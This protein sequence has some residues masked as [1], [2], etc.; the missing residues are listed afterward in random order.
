M[1]LGAGFAMQIFFMNGLLD[2]SYAKLTSTTHVCENIWFSH[3]VLKKQA[4]WI[5]SQ[6][7]H[8]GLICKIQFSFSWCYQYVF[9]TTCFVWSFMWFD[10]ILKFLKMTDYVDFVPYS[11]GHKYFYTSS[12]FT[13]ICNQAGYLLV[14]VLIE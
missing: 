3:M 2:S 10:E 7:S 11:K 9:L 5:I 12:I 4:I 13:K 8:T 6:C 14:N 1:S